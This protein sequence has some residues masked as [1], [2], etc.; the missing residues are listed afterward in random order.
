MKKLDLKREDIFITTKLSPSD[1][2][3]GR[4]R[5]A[6]LDCVKRLGLNYL[7]LMLIHWPGVS[8]LE[9]NDPKNAILRKESWS[10]LETLVN[11][12]VIKSIGVSN[13][14]KNHINELLSHSK[15]LPVINQVEFHPFCHQ[16]ELLEFCSKQKI[17]LQAYSS[18]G[19]ANG[20]DDLKVNESL[21]KLGRMKGKSIPQILLKWAIN[22]SVL[23]IPKTSKIINLPTNLDLFSFDL[24][25]DEMKIISGLNRNHRYS[26]DPNTIR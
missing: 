17:H 2:G 3:S 10:D 26:W 4:A 24:N 25:D 6:A 14:T 23:I 20:W 21:I 16:V 7:D 22:Q 18:L 8:G 15:I 19:S 1:H 11:E 12:G 9:P 13:Y 5:K